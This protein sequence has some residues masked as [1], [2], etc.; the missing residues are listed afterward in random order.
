M[1]WYC[2]SDAVDGKVHS[3]VLKLEKRGGR[4]WGVAECRIRGEFT[5]EELDALKEYD[6]GQA[7]NVWG[8]SFEQRE[9]AYEDKSS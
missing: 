6:T 5:V 2:E 3:V 9:T 4:L 1:H 8:K 7:S